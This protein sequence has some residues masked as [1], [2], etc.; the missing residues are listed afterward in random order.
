MAKTLNNIVLEKL[1]SLLSNAQLDRSFWAEAVVYANHL[2]NRLSSS[3]I[4]GKTP[5]EI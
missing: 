4:G 3:A 1:W 2:M 5:L